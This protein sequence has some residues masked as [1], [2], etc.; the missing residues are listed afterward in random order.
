MDLSRPRA[1]R[2]GSWCVGH[3]LVNGKKV[4]RTV[5][6]RFVGDTV[7]V[8]ESS[9]KNPAIM[10]AT[11]E[12]KGRGIPEWLS[13]EGEM[14]GKVVSMP[15]RDQI[16]LPVFRAVWWFVV[17]QVVPVGGPGPP[18]RT[19]LQQVSKTSS[20]QRS[21]RQLKPR[22]WPAI[23]PKG[24]NAMMWKGFQRPKRLDFERETLTDHWAARS[25]SGAASAPLSVTRSGACCCRRSKA[26]PS[27]RSRSM[28]SCTL[29][30]IR[31]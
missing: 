27:P 31:A 4:E 13:L 28:A 15:T 29:S 1:R 22:L 17:Q 12:V 24:T 11:E 14:G 25:P 20:E 2:H 19:A 5:V 18:W 9:R 21:L 7:V 6:L 23:T 16:D 30:P 8:R 3:F 10:H 26:R